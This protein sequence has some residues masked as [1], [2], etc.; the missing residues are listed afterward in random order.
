MRINRSRGR[1]PWP[2]LLT[3]LALVLI[4]GVSFAGAF[5]WQP[6]QLR[7]LPGRIS[8]GAPQVQEQPPAPAPQ[9]SPPMQPEAPAPQVSPTIH[10]PA[11]RDF[12]PGPFAVA[13]QVGYSQ[14]VG[15]DSFDYAIFFGDSLLTG[16]VAH[17]LL[18]GADVF[19]AIG[20]TP[21]TVLEEPLIPA[22]YDM[23]TMLYAAQKNEGPPSKV[24]I[25]FGGD[26]L[27]LDAEEFIEGYR[28]LIA[29]VRGQ[30]PGATVYIMSMPPV[31]AHVRD[32][33]PGVCRERVIELNGE[34]AELARAIGLPFLN[35]FDALACE[36][37][38][39]PAHASTD[40]LHLS[41]EYHFVLLD[42]LKAH[43]VG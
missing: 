25:M 7:L 11:P 15:A 14:P 29:A 42:F 10:Q 3:L 43:T 37:G 31:A 24:Y 6:G 4:A 39:L 35:I 28:Q 26:S 13:W 16:F 33:H 22:E 32:F 9:D 8:P 19:A 41:A 23:V 12:A 40:G 20:A 36:D 18:P 30:F 17:R 21:Q 38:Y 1:R 2:K 34:I 5:L 27:A